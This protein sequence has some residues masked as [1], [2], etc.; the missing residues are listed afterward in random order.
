MMKSGDREPPDGETDNHYL[1]VSGDALNRVAVPL[2]VVHGRV[3]LLRRHRQRNQPIGSEELDQ[4]LTCLEEATRT[5][6]AELS[7]IMTLSS[8]LRGSADPK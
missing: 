5:M 2:T 4:A 8:R 3:Q 7:G 6:V 1:I